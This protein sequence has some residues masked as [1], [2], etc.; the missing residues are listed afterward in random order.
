MEVGDLVIVRYYG[1]TV[2]MGIIVE[3]GTEWMAGDVLVTWNDGDMDWIA[4]G[5]VM[6]INESR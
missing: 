6:V 2:A 4:K 3:V 1:D 5:N